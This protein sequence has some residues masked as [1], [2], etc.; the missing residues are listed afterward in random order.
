MGGILRPILS[1]YVR[2]ASRQGRLLRDSE[3]NFMNFRNQKVHGS[4]PA[5]DFAVTQVYIGIS[6]IQTQVQPRLLPSATHGILPRDNQ[7]ILVNGV[8]TVSGATIPSGATIETPT[9]WSELTSRAG[10]PRIAPNTKLTLVFSRSETARHQH[11]SGAGL[12]DFDNRQECQRR[13]CCNSG[14]RSDQPDHRRNH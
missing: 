9:M 11:K 5:Y 13:N 3:V 7:P 10:K 2:V 6:A 1:G 8:S 12:R 4:R 14:Q